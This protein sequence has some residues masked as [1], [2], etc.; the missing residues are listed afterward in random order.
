MEAGLT[1]CNCDGLRKIGAV[2]AAESGA[3]EH[4]LMAILGWENAD[5]VRAKP[6]K[7]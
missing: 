2:R 7:K 6:R 4:E 3:S 5:M 1:Q